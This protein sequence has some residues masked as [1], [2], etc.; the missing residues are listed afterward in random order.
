MVRSMTSRWAEPTWWH[1]VRSTFSTDHSNSARN[2]SHVRDP[3]ATAVL[4]DGGGVGAGE[5]SQ[6]RFGSVRLPVW[7]G[8]QT[9]TAQHV[10]LWCVF[11]HGSP[12]TPPLGLSKRPVTQNHGNGG[13]PS[14]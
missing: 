11:D 3:R 5:L 12:E 2:L 4:E 1:T 6:A 9:P 8:L 10:M 13:R 14:G 7:M